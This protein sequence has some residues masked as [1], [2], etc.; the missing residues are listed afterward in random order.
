MKPI[1]VAVDLTPRGAAVQRRGAALAR[2]TG[3][4]LELFHVLG[5]YAGEPAERS[6]AARL[7]L[8]AANLR[9]DF[10]IEVGVAL[11]SGRVA[12]AITERARTVGARMV[13]M[14]AGRPNGWRRLLQASRAHAV[15]R[16]VRSPV[17]A[18]ASGGASAHRRVLFAT[19]LSGEDAATLHAVRRDWPLASLLLLHVQSWP[20][21]ADYREAA[22]AQAWLA[23]RRFAVQHDLER[24][25]SL[26]AALG[27]VAR[28]LRLRA[29]EFGADLLVLSPER[30][31][32]K[33]LLGASVT[34]SVL[35]DPPC[36]VLLA[37]PPAPGPAFRPVGIRSVLR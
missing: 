31:R 33:A 28:M 5:R 2:A 35:G 12:A 16:A 13:V 6:A 20:V 18:V 29:R 7:R 21:S 37:P 36:D 14:G 17:L 30:S 26:E 11:A 32:L 1:L 10:A 15:Q 22:E 27:D 9:D 25:I 23:L 19:D 3:A 34:Q 4:P 8:A 24:A